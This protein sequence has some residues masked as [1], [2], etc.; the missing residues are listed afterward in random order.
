MSK[1]LQQQRPTV[2]E[3]PQ[4]MIAWVTLGASLQNVIPFLCVCPHKKEDSPD[5]PYNLLQAQDRIFHVLSSIS[6]HLASF[7]SRYLV[8]YPSCDSILSVLGLRCLTQTRRADM[9]F[10]QH[11]I[12]RPSSKHPSWCNADIQSRV[13]LK[14]VIRP[15]FGGSR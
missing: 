14:I 2:G 5:G 4:S 13:S 1:I 9:F 10:S 7:H 12:S 3:A 11:A 15:F 6:S 8:E